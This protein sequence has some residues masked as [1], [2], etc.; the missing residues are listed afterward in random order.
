MSQNDINPHFNN[1]RLNQ[2]RINYSPVRKNPP[3]DKI[4]K[5]DD[6]VN[7][8]TAVGECGIC[9]EDKIV[10]F[11]IF[12]CGHDGYCED[13]LLHMMQINSKCPYC[14]GPIQNYTR[15]YTTRKFNNIPSK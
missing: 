11:V 12:P 6:I 5:K 13:C 8:F 4:F 3:I 2:S 10:A 14:R 9:M 7:D 1:Q 15:L